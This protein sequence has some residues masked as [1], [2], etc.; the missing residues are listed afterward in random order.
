M[1]AVSSFKN[2]KNYI[3]LYRYTTKK[4]SNIQCVYVEF[5]I[6]IEIVKSRTNILTLCALLY[7]KLCEMS[8]NLLC[9]FVWFV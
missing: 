6:I 9:E 3:N 2:I 7:N 1:Q 8:K 5:F 4:S